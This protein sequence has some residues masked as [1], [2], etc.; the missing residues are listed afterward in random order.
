MS[1]ESK[2]PKEWMIEDLKNKD[3]VI[4]TCPKCRNSTFIGIAQGFTSDNKPYP[5]GECAQCL[6]SQRRLDSEKDLELMMEFRGERW[7][8]WVKFCLERDYRPC[9]D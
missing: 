7:D 1:M 5:V 6:D 4:I 8:E 2:G 9:V 3:A